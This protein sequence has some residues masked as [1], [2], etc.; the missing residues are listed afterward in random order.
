MKHIRRRRLRGVGGTREWWDGQKR[1]APSTPG[2]VLRL[3]FLWI[4]SPQTALSRSPGR[5]APRTTVPSSSEW[6]NIS[7]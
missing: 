6:L 3:F 7:A 1:P 2:F 4:S 5:R